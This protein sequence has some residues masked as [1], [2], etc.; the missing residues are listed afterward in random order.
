M[1]YKK[2]PITIIKHEIE[3]TGIFDSKL[4][5]RFYEIDCKIISDVSYKTHQK[6]NILKLNGFVIAEVG[7]SRCLSKVVREISFEKKYKIYQSTPDANKS[8][9]IE[10][11]SQCSIAVDEQ[12]FLI[13]IFEEELIF[14]AMQTFNHSECLIFNY[15]K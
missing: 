13:E 15:R 1:D 8:Y 9:S 4:F 7:C 11:F 3:D 2:N 6:K 10:N 12:I 5:K 14:E